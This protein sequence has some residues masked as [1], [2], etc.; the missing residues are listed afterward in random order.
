MEKKVTE[1]PSRV[2]IVSKS[3]F[4]RTRPD[5]PHRVW[6]AEGWSS[7]PAW[8]SADGADGVSREATE[9]EPQYRLRKNIPN[10]S[11]CQMGS[12]PDLRRGSNKRRG[13]P[14]ACPGRSIADTSL[15]CLPYP[16]YGGGLLC[17]SLYGIRSGARS[18]T[19]H[20]PLQADTPYPG[21]LFRHLFFLIGAEGRTHTGVPTRA[22]PTEKK[23]I[24][25]GAV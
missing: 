13:S 22:Y 21:P 4:P 16:L 14:E 11:F 19:C 2:G 8:V 24:R 25:G 17:G 15:C 3:W 1:G 12:L 7:A 9:R 5:L 23:V 20:L 6:V 10:G 18:D